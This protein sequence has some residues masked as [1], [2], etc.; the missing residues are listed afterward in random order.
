MSKNDKKSWLD[1]MQSFEKISVETAFN[2]GATSY[3]QH[4]YFPHEDENAPYIIPMIQIKAKE[5]EAR[6]TNVRIPAELEAT[7]KRLAPGAPIANVI[8][9]LADLKA[10]E[11][12]TDNKSVV[13]KRKD[14]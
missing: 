13:I 14:K 1:D 3:W 4:E 6:L 7:I 8:L 2:K 9:A 12:L 10:S 11:L 5:D